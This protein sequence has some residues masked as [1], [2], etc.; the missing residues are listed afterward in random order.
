MWLVF[1]PTIETAHFS[2]ATEILSLLNN[3]QALIRERK[4]KLFIRHIRKHWGLP[5]PWTTEYHLTNLLTRGEEILPVAVK[6]AQSSHALHHQNS[7]AL[8]SK[9]ALTR[10]QA[11]QVVKQCPHCPKVFHSPQVKVNPQ[12]IKPQVL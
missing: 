12:G 9:F 5:S 7:N 6:K 2:R 4:E 3:L 10:E 1:F 8:R 11:R